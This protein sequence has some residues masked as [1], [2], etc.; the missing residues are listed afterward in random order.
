MRYFADQ[1]RVKKE[2]TME[3]QCVFDLSEIMIVSRAHELLKLSYFYL[4][5]TNGNCLGST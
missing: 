4:F 3:I 1:L 2:L 5:V